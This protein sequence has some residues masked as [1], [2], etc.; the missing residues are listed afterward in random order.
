[1]L[2]VGIDIS[3]DKVDIAVYDGDRY[4]TGIFDNS[5]KGV[6]RMLAFV[7]KNIKS[8][9][10]ASNTSNRRKVSKQKGSAKGKASGRRK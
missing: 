1:M 10:R 2:S 8:Y 6:N 9:G 4:V 5:V 7:L 3:K